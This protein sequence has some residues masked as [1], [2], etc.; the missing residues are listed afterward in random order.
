MRKFRKEKSHGENDEEDNFGQVQNSEST[1]SSESSER[2]KSIF[3]TFR[4]LDLANNRTPILG[5]I[6]R[7]KSIRY[8]VTM[9]QRV[10]VSIAV[11]LPCR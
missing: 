8:V 3:R 5:S 6:Y 11:N 4:A 2:T 7:G 1:D 10:M 9:F